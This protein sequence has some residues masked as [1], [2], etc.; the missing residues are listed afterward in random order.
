MACVS[1]N[2]LISN[3]SQFS[4]H[5][6][7]V[8]ELWTHSWL[9]ICTSFTLI[10][11]QRHRGVHLCVSWH[12][13]RAS[14]RDWSFRVE[15]GWPWYPVG[16]RPSWSWGVVNSAHYKDSPPA[17]FRLRYAGR[18]SDSCQA[19]WR[20]LQLLSQSRSTDL[21]RWQNSAPRS[22]KGQTNNWLL[23]EI[24]FLDKWNTRLHVSC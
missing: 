13:R 16:G 19:T 7:T 2:N 6:S 22:C 18:N 3:H 9:R 24:G 10:V 17:V 20:G 14:A 8:S 11:R 5:C 4:S 15:F 21:V 23:V 12:V 1:A